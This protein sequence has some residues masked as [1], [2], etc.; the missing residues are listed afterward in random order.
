[1]HI[2]EGYG[3][4]VPRISRKQTT[5]TMSDGIN[6]RLVPHYGTTRTTFNSILSL[7]YLTNLKLNLKK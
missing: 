3:Q 1:M 6:R 4:L 5:R 2:T 7:S